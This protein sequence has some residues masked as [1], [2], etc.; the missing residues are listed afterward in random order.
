LGRSVSM[1]WFG[2]CMIIYDRF[3]S[4]RVINESGCG[5]AKG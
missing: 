4:R 2:D 1:E 3:H 5:S